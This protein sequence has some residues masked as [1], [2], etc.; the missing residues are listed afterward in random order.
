MSHNELALKLNELSRA[1]FLA[2][3]VN[4]PS[5]TGLLYKLAGSSWGGLTSTP[6]YYCN[7]VRVVKI[8][9]LGR[10]VCQ[11][12]QH[13]GSW[14]MRLSVCTL[15]IPRTDNLM[16]N[17]SSAQIK[18]TRWQLH[19]HGGWRSKAPWPN[20]WCHHYLKKW[21]TRGC[22]VLARGMDGD[23]AYNICSWI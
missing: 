12:Y 17:I 19:C 14:C 1:R 3:F 8:Y 5:W 16:V 7:L 22:L 11:L 2:R 23:I 15:V 21:T 13:F 20:A 10:E 6:M 4:Q 9:E 18:K